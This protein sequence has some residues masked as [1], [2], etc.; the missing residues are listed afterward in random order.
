MLAAASGC[1][2]AVPPPESSDE[3]T[4]VPVTARPAEVGSLRAV[5]HTTGIVTPAQ[6]AEFL[7]T[8]LETARIL[9]VTKAVGDAVAAGDILVRFDAGTAVANVARQRAELAGAQALAE[10]ARIAHDRMRDFV[11]RGLVARQEI[12][13]ADRDLAD[14]HAR[15]A[16]AQA[17]LA[18]AEAMAARANI[19]APFA[20]IVA[21]R[22]R[23]PGDVAS[24]TET[25]VRVVDP[26][27][28]DVVAIVADADVPRVVPGASAR[29]TSGGLVTRLTVAGRADHTVS[30]DTPTVRLTFLEPSSVPVD[31]AVEVDIDAEERTGA[32][33]V[34]AEALVREGGQAGREAVL[35]IAAGN[36]AERRAVTVGVETDERVEITSG[37]KAGELVITRGQSGLPD[38]AAIS[39]D[40]GH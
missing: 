6:G 27:R 35:F 30:P 17:A 32:I 18:A 1:R 19:R 36:A 40:L 25:V 4:A 21:N 29:L 31:M 13:R 39:V 12:D 37:I 11:D 38:G 20:G 34:P 16:R 15:V 14:A 28:L 5:I 7:V 22:F 23:N 2:R 10:N 33:F 8:P 9:E 3:V 24:A 26:R